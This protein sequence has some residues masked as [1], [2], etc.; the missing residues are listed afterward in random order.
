[1]ATL[2]SKSHERAKRKQS[3]VESALSN[4]DEQLLATTSTTTTTTIAHKE[5]QEYTP[6]S[7][8]ANFRDLGLAD[9]LV[10]TCTALG[11]KRPSPVQRTI[12]PFL[13]KEESA[14]VLALAETGSGKTAAFVL[15]ILHR[16]SSDPYGIYAVI[17]SPTRELAKQIHQQ[18]LA[19]GASYNVDAALVVGGLD[20]VRQSCALDRKPHFVVA[21]PGRLAELLRGPNPPQL[22]LI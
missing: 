13:L 17:V 16:L 22:I 20:M 11:F 1:M 3:E 2:F 21:T 8:W 10:D 5:L 18:V 19:L 9:P 6:A 4:E 14:H 7:R 15:P 12:I